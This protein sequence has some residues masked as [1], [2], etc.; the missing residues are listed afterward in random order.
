MV[1]QRRRRCSHQER[2]HREERCCDS[3]PRSS[4]YRHPAKSVAADEAAEIE[5][6]R[7]DSDRGAYSVERAKPHQNGEHARPLHFRK[8][9]IDSNAKIGN[10]TSAANLDNGTLAAPR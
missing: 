4:A 6:H 3:Q 2:D 5:Q 8:N 7:D 1:L 9:K 10:S